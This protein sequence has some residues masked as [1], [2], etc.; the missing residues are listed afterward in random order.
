VVKAMYRDSA[1]FIPTLAEISSYLITHLKPGDVL[2]TMSAGDADQ[3]SAQVLTHLQNV[4][5]ALHKK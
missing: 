2:I 5:G 1:H 3:V 4:Q